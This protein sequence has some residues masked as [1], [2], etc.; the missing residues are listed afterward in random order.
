MASKGM[1][2]TGHYD[3]E[4]YMKGRQYYFSTTLGAAYKVMDNLS[5]F[6]GARFLYGT[7]RYEGYVKNIQMGIAPPVMNDGNPTPAAT[8][9][10]MI[11]AQQDDITLDCNQ[12]G[13]GV[14]PFI[15]VDYKIGRLNLATKFDFKVRMRL[16]ND[17]STPITV[18][19]LDKYADGNIV[20]EDSPAL[21]TIG[22]QYEILDNWRVMVGYHHFFDVDTKQY[23][24]NLVGDTNEFNIGTE[25]DITDWL[26]V[27]GGF[28]KTIYDQTDAFMSDLS[29]NVSSYSFGLGVGVK[30]CDN[31]KLN[32]AYFQTNYDTYKKVEEM[33]GIK[34]CNNFTR[35][36]R[37]LGLGVEWDF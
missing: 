15:G 3:L 14:A 8:P 37:V 32:A 16:K 19:Q 6:A 21:F 17:T 35:T 28:Q 13:F 5:V 29:F 33:G 18:P 25:Y 9:A 34:I 20:P 27:S 1:M 30:V 4:S 22:A 23:T 7:A 11:P 2:L 24:K 12:S 26:Q 36:N 10:E 31:V